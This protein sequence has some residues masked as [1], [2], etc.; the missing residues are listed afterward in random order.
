MNAELRE[1]FKLCSKICIKQYD[2]DK[3]SYK[4]KVCLNACF[5]EKS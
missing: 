5:V 3:L 2:S 1:T 4:E